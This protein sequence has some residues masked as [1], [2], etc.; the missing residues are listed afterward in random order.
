MPWKPADDLAQSVALEVLLH[1]PLARV[2][3]ARRL[4]LAPAT[5]TRISAELIDVGLLVETPQLAERRAGRPSIPLDV[6]AEAHYF[7]GIKL[8]GDAV[9]AAVTNLRAG[10]VNYFELALSSTEP[11]TVVERIAAAAGRAGGSYPI[12]AIGIG[13]GGVVAGDGSVSSAPFLGWTDVPLARLVQQAT[14]IPA[15]AAND[16]TAFME[17]QHWFGL[18]A[19]HD[20]FAALTLGV[21]VGFGCVA[22]GRL[23]ANDDSG[24]GLVGHWPLDPLGPMCNRGH[25]GCAESMLTVP[26]I[27][28][29]ISTAL[30]R[31]V[32]W[33]EFLSLV[34]AGQ[35][36]AT[37]IATSSGRALGRLIAA[38]ANLVAPSFVVVGGEGVDLAAVSARAVDEGIREQRDPRASTVKVELTS[39]T[40][41]S[42]CRGAAVIALQ[43]YV[44][45]RRRVASHRPAL[46]SIDT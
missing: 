37:G 20:N 32:D 26:A 10:V 31:P 43:G 28:R 34:R 4:D 23:L 18:G 22:N 40:N 38:V 24:V 25:R 41:E 17:A 7:L 29:D 21:G 12:D 45:D 19:G 14:G 3:L 39:G 1:G 6:V 8:T 30:D 5:L 36:A 46:S 15:F 11:E 42:W 27:L 16:L 2:E 44:L 9:M 13:L 35:P 33:T